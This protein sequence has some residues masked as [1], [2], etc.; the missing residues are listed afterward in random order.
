[1]NKAEIFVNVERRLARFSYFY[2]RMLITSS[3]LYGTVPGIIQF[4]A[5]ITGTV[6]E[7]TYEAPFHDM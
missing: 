5:Y 3:A 2:E 6:T 7:K 1:M 4:Q